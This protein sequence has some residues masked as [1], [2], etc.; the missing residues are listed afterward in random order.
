V[1]TFVR[2]GTAGRERRRA[3]LALVGDILSGTHDLGR[4]LTAVLRA[5]LALTGA[6]AGAVLLLDGSGAALAGYH[7]GRD[8]GAEAP[9]TPV[10]VPLAGSL[11][12]SVVV[13]GTARRG[14]ARPDDL[15]ADEPRC[16][17]YLAVPISV[18][19][20]NAAGAPPWPVPRT[21]RGVLALY[22]LPRGRRRAGDLAAL[23]TFAGHAA[24]AVDN[25]RIHQEAQ[26]LS[27]TD[28][29]TGLWN[30][31]HLRDALRREV[32]RAS[33]FGRTL[34]VLALD[35]DHFKDVNDV[36]GHP[37]GDAVLA[38]V[39]RRITAEIREVDFAFRQGGEEFVVVLPETEARG[40]VVVARRLVAAVRDDPVPVVPR[41]AARSVPVRV[42]ISAG[43]AVYPDHGRT[44]ETLLDA[45]DDALY[46]AKAAGRDTH[47]TAPP[48]PDAADTAVAAELPVRAGA[49][50]PE[51]ELPRA[52]GAAEPASG[53]AKP[54]R[55]SRG[56]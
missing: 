5:A 1:R 21:V 23:R 17:T 28:P 36:Y 37:A 6:R 39:A 11:L 35:L 13:T 30:Y 56:R 44:P 14:R 33:R 27:L 43:V 42:T 48:Y 54:P 9:A 4:V 16:R 34:T 10:E 55:Q 20:G 49:R 31:R 32:E 3:R 19:D 46:A 53:E 38:E 29:L 7:G 41:G 50:T 52:G 12:G 26:R 18:P 8:G 45:A 40:G 25:V 15:H 51:G 22:D 24:V 2:P 47:R